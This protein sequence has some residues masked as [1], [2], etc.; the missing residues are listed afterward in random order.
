MKIRIFGTESLGVRGLSCLVETRSSRIFID[1]GLALGFNR[2]GLQPHPVQAAAGERV[3]AEILEA[4]PN[5]TDIVISHF[6]GDHVP[7]VHANPYQLPARQAAPLFKKANLWCKSPDT[8]RMNQRFIDLS[9]LLDQAPVIAEGRTHGPVSFSLPVPHGEARTRQSTVM[10]TR[11]EDEGCVFVHASD[12]QLMDGDTVSEILEW[13]PDIVFVSGP[14]VYLSSIPASAVES[15]LHNAERLAQKVDVL[16][17]DHH[18]LR[19]NEGFR[20]LD[21]LDSAA[22]QRVICAADY[23]GRPRLPLEARRKYLYQEIPVPEGWHRDYA[24]G[25]V[26]AGSCRMEGRLI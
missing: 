15:A 21:D 18:L 25:K 13:H 23:M 26:D 8:D 9:E 10:M 1:P 12:S 19:C 24:Q 17:M 6:H 2:G 14:P 5:C 7:L 22:R 4:L 20:Y 3:R 11:I 16:I